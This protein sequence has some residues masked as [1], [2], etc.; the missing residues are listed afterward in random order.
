MQFHLSTKQ[1]DDALKPRQPTAKNVHKRPATD[2][3]K[4]SSSS[5]P[6][7]STTKSNPPKKK[8]GKQ[9]DKTNKEDAA[10][11]S[12][13][14]KE[15]TC[16]KKK[17]AKQKDKTKKDEAVK[18]KPPVQEPASP[19]NK[20]AKQKNKTKK[21]EAVKTNS[22]VQ[23]TTSPKKKDSKQKEKKSKEDAATTNVSLKDL[24][25]PKKDKKKK[26]KNAAKT[27]PS[28]KELISPIKKK[29]MQKVKINYYVLPRYLKEASPKKKRKDK[30]KKDAVMKQEEANFRSKTDNTE[31]NATETISSL[32]QEPILKFSSLSSLEKD[33]NLDALI[34]LDDYLVTDAGNINKDLEDPHEE[35]EQDHITSVT[36]HEGERR[37]DDDSTRLPATDQD[38]FPKSKSTKRPKS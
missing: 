7:T 38:K 11:S 35:S 21:D 10:K 15:P 34:I 5:V 32:L 17:E 23:E 28:L 16:P 14:L 22:S 36:F 30:A 24:I 18:T 25:S 31:K 20:E 12:S 2:E 29:G 3:L 26:D 13:F 19:K 27:S 4:S 33:E 9:K 6:G 8:E 1:T 37:T